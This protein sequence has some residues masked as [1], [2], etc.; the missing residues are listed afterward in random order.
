MNRDEYERNNKELQKYTT[1]P[2][3]NNLALLIARGSVAATQEALSTS[4]HP[5]DVG[6]ETLVNLMKTVTSVLPQQEGNAN[7][8]YTHQIIKELD[9]LLAGASE[10]DPLRKEIEETIRITPVSSPEGNKSFHKHFINSSYLYD[11][12][13]DSPKNYTIDTISSEIAAKLSKTNDA[14]TRVKPAVTIIEIL[15]PK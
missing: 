14:P 5:V 10:S 7:G 1:L 11:G 9:N 2:G 3:G 8:R 13:G 12:K 15:K 6:N 4:T